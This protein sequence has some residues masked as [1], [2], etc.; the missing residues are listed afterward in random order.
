MSPFSRFLKDSW[1]NVTENRQVPRSAS[2]SPPGT[3]GRGRSGTEAGTVQLGDGP[4]LRE[5]EVSR[6][7]NALRFR[8]ADEATR[9]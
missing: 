1:P 9:R 2:S 6:R 7:L 4:S 3:N 5:R 8:H